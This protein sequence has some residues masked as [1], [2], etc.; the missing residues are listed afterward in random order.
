MVN[1]RQRRAERRE[2][3]QRIQIT[4][5]EKAW[6]FLG[7]NLLLGGALAM[8]ALGFS[9]ELANKQPVSFGFFVVGFAFLAASIYRSRLFESLS[10]SLKITA[11][12]LLLIAIFVPVFVAWWFAWPETPIEQ[13][14]HLALVKTILTVRPQVTPEGK[15][16]SLTVD[17]DFAV[18]NIG[19][20]RSL[21]DAQIQVRPMIR[22]VSLKGEGEDQL[23]QTPSSYDP[24]PMGIPIPN[25]LDSGKGMEWHENNFFLDY[26][27]MGKGQV[28]DLM[29]GKKVLYITTEF[30][31]SDLAGRLRSTSCGYHTATDGFSLGRSCWTHDREVEEVPESFR[32]K[33][34]GRLRRL[35]GR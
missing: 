8:W 20:M 16:S 25:I 4:G 10:L 15:Y 2:R 32:K 13:R 19:K 3:R 14:A 27:I 12:S 5:A 31:Y 30:E 9:F 28:T 18:E 1:S 24:A 35:I 21:P 33:L 29:N 26:P 7:H 22:P 17:A 11:Q 23:F 34:T 6:D